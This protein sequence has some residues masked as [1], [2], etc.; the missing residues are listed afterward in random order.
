MPCSKCG[1]KGHNIQTC[2][3]HAKRKSFPQNYPKSKRCQCCGQYGYEIQKH[4][5][6]GRGDI[7]PNAHLDVCRSCHV[8][9]C[10]NGHFRNLPIKPGVCR[11]LR[12][13]SYWRTQI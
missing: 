13:T 10:H 7:S 8:H 11:F 6:K 4:H 3:Y 1:K 9:C 2:S 12:R 5:T